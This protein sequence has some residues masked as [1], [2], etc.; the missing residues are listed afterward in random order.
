MSG[1]A[2]IARPWFYRLP[3]AA[4]DLIRFAAHPR[5]ETRYLA[6][7]KEF[8]R[9]LRPIIAAFARDVAAGSE[10]LIH[11][12]H[13]FVPSLKE[14]ALF[15]AMLRASGLR[16]VFLTT[17]FGGLDRYIRIVPG[18]RVV[19][20]EDFD[21]Q[22]T[23]AD[24]RIAAGI[25]GEAGDA[26]GLIDAE[27]NGIAV[28]R[29]TLSAFMRKRYLGSVDLREHRDALI[30][31]VA[32]ALAAART[33]AAILERERAPT[34]LMNERGYTPSGEFFDVAL[35]LGRRVVQWQA[36]HRDDGRIFKAYS[37]S[38]RTD[39]P[40]SISADTWAQALDAP[41]SDADGDRLLAYLENCYARK[42]WFNFKRLQHLTE[43]LPPHRVIAEIGLDPRKPTAV[44]FAHILWDA[45][46]FFGDGLYDDY[47]E[48]LVETIRVAN[49]S[50]SVNW[51]VKLHP[52]NVWRLAAD[53]AD[54]TTFA[55]LAALEHA[56][57]RVAP[58]VKIL[59]PDTPVSTWSLFRV[60]DYCFTVRGTVGIEMAAL[61]KRVVTAGT[62]HYAAH[63]FT[64]DPRTR[65]DYEAI[66]RDPTRLQPMS[67]SE[68]HRALRFAHVLF[69]RRPVCFD[70]YRLEH[71]DAA[72]VFH[73]LN[74][75]ARMLSPTGAAFARSTIAARWSAWLASS[76]TEDCLVDDDVPAAAPSVVP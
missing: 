58:H 22:P 3:P 45:T 36:S 62:G 1:L 9:D 48:W 31:T 7:W 13:G 35:S 68:R 55:E 4:R 57:I 64:V 50:T 20:R 61:G 51:V 72:D 24:A 19:Y 40:S 34:I 44:L 37:T 71:S 12:T 38:T 43:D 73:P 56:G 11:S 28:G 6:D 65:D 70:T 41:F 39:H 53:G 75:R 21:G 16:P 76:T 66:V 42:T 15:G 27:W 5:R 54:G 60:A 25:V 29:H 49:E 46:F 74:G 69:E 67:E 2:G 17:R 26:R 63:G 18:A 10:V 33:S 59:M 8:R 30:A 14:E 32:C 23:A 47:R 52:V